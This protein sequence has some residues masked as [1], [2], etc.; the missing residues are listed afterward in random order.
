MTGLRDRRDAY[1]LRRN[2]AVGE[3]SRAGIPRQEALW[4]LCS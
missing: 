4:G 1:A 3:G 2:A